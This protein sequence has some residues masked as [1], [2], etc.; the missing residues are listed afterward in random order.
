MGAVANGVRGAS[1]VGSVLI[2]D[3]FTAEV[4]GSSFVVG[5]CGGCGG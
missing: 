5:G 2:A 4:V 1:P 3:D